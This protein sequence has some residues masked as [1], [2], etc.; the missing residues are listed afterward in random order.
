MKTIRKVEED[1]WHV[2]SEPGDATRYD[3]YIFRGYN[4]TYH[5]MPR[6]NDFKY[7]QMLNIT[8]AKFIRTVDMVGTLE[9]YPTINP[10][11][12]NECAVTIIELHEGG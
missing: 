2:T 8:D 7:P 1:L 3:F 10:Y 5:I 4:S 6:N 11:T 9:K 12:M